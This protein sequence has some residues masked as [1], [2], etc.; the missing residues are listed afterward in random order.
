MDKTSFGDRIKKMIPQ[1]KDDFNC[2][3]MVFFVLGLLLVGSFAAYFFGN[4]DPYPQSGNTFDITPGKVILF[5]SIVLA[6]YETVCII[7]IIIGYCTRQ[8]K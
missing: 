5:V 8:D 1:T 3:W 7:A 4:G 6:F 2:Y